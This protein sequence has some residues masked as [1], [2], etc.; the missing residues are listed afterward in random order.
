MPETTRS[1]VLPLA[2]L[3]A[4]QA[5]TAALG[6]V[7]MGFAPVLAQPAMIGPVE[8]ETIL[9]V[10]LCAL[11]VMAGWLRCGPV[12]LLTAAPALALLPGGG[13]PLLAAWSLAGFTGALAL[14]QLAA[15]N[16]EMVRSLR[17]E[18]R[19]NEHERN[20]LHRHIQR[21]PALLE[22]CLELSAARELDQF[23]T[24]LCQRA[25][26][27]LPEIQEVLVFLGSSS[28]LEC[29]ASTDR[30]GQPC[31]RAAGDDE[32]YVAAEA[33]SLLRRQ[34]HEV[35]ILIPLRGDRR[36]QDVGGEAL[37]GVLAV[38]L[39]TGD[40]SDRLALELLD[41]LGR[42]GGLGLAAVDLVNQARG[43]A[44]KDDL[45]GLYG[46]HEFL[47][48]LKE[49]VAACRRGQLTL[50]VVM[51]DMDHLK[52]FNDEFG[53]LAGDAALRAVAQAISTILP[54]E[55]I[56]CRY[57]GEEF[58]AVVPGRDAAGLATL[59]EA[60]RHA[61]ANARPD[62]TQPDRRVT[63]SLGVT[64]LRPDEEA[65]AALKRADAAC[66]QAKAKGRNRVEV[67]S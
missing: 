31:P 30:D 44:L 47:R 22:A 37:R 51:C 20:L 15:P 54:P 19:D 8:A 42:L 4:A 41:A 57:G 5:A 25:R 45:T 3:T 36:Q 63:A 62:P 35:R 11:W 67:V 18:L 27:L 53:H 60:L 52:R 65:R 38:C 59:G 43:L 56:A 23:A 21:Y 6:L 64:M 50:G 61:I 29:C 34:N 7:E 17:N 33:R 13:W 26:E 39:V 1:L 16:P 48:R 40:F 58:A 28:E 10:G 24:V 66:Y 46:Q 2:V 14:H 49:Q 12:A 55:A 9:A 32:L